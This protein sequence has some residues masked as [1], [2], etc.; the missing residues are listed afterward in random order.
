MERK[1]AHIEKISWIKPIKD[2]DKIE[3]CGI[4]GWQCVIAKKENFKIGDKVIYIEIDSIV[5]E[6]K[7]EFEFPSE[8]G[9]FRIRTV[10]LRGEISQG[11]V[12]PISYLSDFSKYDIGDDVTEVLG[13][14]KYLSPSEREEFEQEERKVHNEKNKLKKVYDEIF[15]VQKTCSFKD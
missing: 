6:K 1:L 8:T 7:P 10:K 12:I 3:L 11:L 14:V 15:L 2:A 5:P 4:L 9:R 13:I